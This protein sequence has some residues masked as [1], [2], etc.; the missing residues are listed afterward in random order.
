MRSLILLTL[1]ANGVTTPVLA[2]GTARQL[3]CP[4][5][6]SYCYYTERPIRSGPTTDDAYRSVEQSLECWKRQNAMNSNMSAPSINLH[7][8][9]FTLPASR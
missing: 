7:C 1:L 6:L 2:Q 4:P 9:Q 3:V 5:T 8:E